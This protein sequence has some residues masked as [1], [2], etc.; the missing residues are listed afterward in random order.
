MCQGKAF[1]LWEGEKVSAEVCSE[2]QC[3]RS[4]GFFSTSGLLVTASINN[5]LLIFLALTGS[6]DLVCIVQLNDP[7][8]KFSSSVAKNAAHPFWKEEFIL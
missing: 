3:A 2:V 1:I 6:T 4:G 7:M 5:W 8:Q